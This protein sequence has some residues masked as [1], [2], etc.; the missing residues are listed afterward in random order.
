MADATGKASINIRHPAQWL[1]LVIGVV[2]T[3]V[4]LI[5][6]AVTG[7]DSGFASP[8]GE[9]LLGVFEINPLHNVVHL[10][11]GVVGIVLATGLRRATTYGWLLLVGY[12]LAFLYGLA[13]AG[14]DEAANF[15]ALNWGDNWLHLVSALLG[16]VIIV[17]AR[18]PAGRDRGAEPA[19]PGAQRQGS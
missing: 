7:F 12:G 19:P 11:I 5:G 1:A 14:S 8:D 17:L 13:V 15:L 10:V 2:Y 3:L 18:R 4:G 6:F 9:L 16:A